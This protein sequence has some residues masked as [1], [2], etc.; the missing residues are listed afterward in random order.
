L[1]GVLGLEGAPF[2]RSVRALWHLAFEAFC[3]YLATCLTG[4]LSIRK[5]QQLGSQFQHLRQLRFASSAAPS[6]AYSG[7]TN[8]KSDGT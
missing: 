4:V 2:L 6:S 1:G 7:L 5:V 8:T 3:A